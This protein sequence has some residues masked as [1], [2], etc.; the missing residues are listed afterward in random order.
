MYEVGIGGCWDV[1]AG[2]LVVSEAGGQLLDPSG[3]P[4]DLMSRRVL[5]A[6]AHLALP[7]SELLKGGPWA[8]NEPAPTQ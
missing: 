1:A 6:N 3:G 8:D 5:A 4:F 2:A 7:I